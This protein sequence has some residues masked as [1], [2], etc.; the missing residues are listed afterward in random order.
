MALSIRASFPDTTGAAPRQIDKPTGALEDDLLL[1]LI[2]TADDVVPTAPGSFVL[3]AEITGTTR[4]SV[5]QK[6]ATADEPE[7]YWL[8]WPSGNGTAAIFAIVASS[9]NIPSVH[10]TATASSEVASTSKVWAEVTTTFADTLLLCFGG[11]GTL[12]TSTPDASMTER[13]DSGSPRAYLMTQAVVAAGATGTRTATGNSVATQRCITVALTESATSP[14]TYPPGLLVTSLPVL[15]ELTGEGVDV[16]EFVTLAEIGALGVYITQMGVLVEFALDATDFYAVGD[17]ADLPASFL[18]RLT[19]QPHCK[20]VQFTR[21]H[22][23]NDGVHDESYFLVYEYNVLGSRPM[24]R[25]VLGQLGLL[26]AQENEITCT[27]RDDAGVWQ[28]W[29]GTAVR[30]QQQEDVNYARSFP[31]NIGILVKDLRLAA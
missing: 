16:T 21:D 27:A 31:R 26:A 1:L 14:I 7:W 3:V 9:P 19:P 25:D 15:A 28:R 6:V 13:Y 11:F 24:Y 29:S 22:T 5:F 10:A 4:T 18:Q 12:A 20:G 30:P 17:G 8:N 23:G 2:V